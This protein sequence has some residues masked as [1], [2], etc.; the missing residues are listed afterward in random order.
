M[1]YLDLLKGEKFEDTDLVYLVSYQDVK[2]VLKISKN[3]T[4]NSIHEFFVSKTIHDTFKCFVNI[5][6]PIS[7][8]W[9]QCNVNKYE[10]IC[11]SEHEYHESSRWSFG[12]LSE[13]ING[14]S[15]AKLISKFKERTMLNNYSIMTSILNQ[16]LSMLSIMN[17]RTQF[18]HYD[19]HTNNILCEPCD[20]NTVLFYD[21]D[22]TFPL[23][24]F[25]CGYIAKIVDFEYSSISSFSTFETNVYFQPSKNT[26]PHVT[27]I[28]PQFDGKL[29]C[30]NLGVSPNVN[31]P[32]FDIKRFV[33]S[34]FLT[35]KSYHPKDKFIHNVCNSFH[36]MF[37]RN[38]KLALNGLPIK[39]QDSIKNK[40][41]S[42][43]NLN[44]ETIDYIDHTYYSILSRFG[45]FS[46]IYPKKSETKNSYKNVAHLI[47]CVF[48]LKHTKNIDNTKFNRKIETALWIIG[49]IECEVNFDEKIESIVQLLQPYTKNS[50]KEWIKYIIYLF[51]FYKSDIENIF[52][53]M[54]SNISSKLNNPFDHK[55][56]IQLLHYQFNQ[57]IIHFTK[58]S[59][60]IWMRD[61]KKTE[62]SFKNIP[63]RYLEKLN[64][65]KDIMKASLFLK[66]ILNKH[67]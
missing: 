11:S 46:N 19:L 12:L 28:K 2:Y 50:V 3:S 26:T 66:K 8:E 6:K 31:N 58:N 35:F 59:R 56:I 1:D 63:D 57:Q 67:F 9:F 7:V 33:T 55:E 29:D 40:I 49:F 14:I 64:S 32:D 65:Y 47:Q 34:T 18:T 22:I 20:Q 41:L 52:Y 5:I 43:L 36:N 17:K 27:S 61:N 44:Q 13:Y 16:T 62:I 21:S 39:E 4:W 51:D 60:I 53:K 48:S 24:V 10:Y 25:T 38:G 30:Y 42:Y 37:N 15:F 54:G 45:R 23:I